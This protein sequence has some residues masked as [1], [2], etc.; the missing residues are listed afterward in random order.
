MSGR[1]LWG[2]LRARLGRLRRGDA[3]R[4]GLEVEMA[5]LSRQVEEMSTCLQDLCREV[6]R[7]GKWHLEWTVQL[8]DQAESWEQA[9]QV[10]RR[11]G[12]RY[13]EAMAELRREGE[14]YRE[15]VASVRDTERREAQA[16]VLAVL[17]EQ[18]L[19]LVDGLEAAL[20]SLSAQEERGVATGEV[21][22]HTQG[23]CPEPEAL[24]RARAGYPEPE[25]DSAARAGY[26]EREAV[27]QAMEGYLTRCQE[28]LAGLGIERLE[29]VGRQFDPYCHRAVEAIPVAEESLAGKVLAEVAAG[30]AW[31]GQVIR[32][33]Q[34]VVGKWPAGGGNRRVG[35]EPTD[36]DR[37]ARE[38]TGDQG[39][40]EVTGAELAGAEEESYGDDRGNRSGHDE[41]GS[42][43]DPG[44]P[45]PGPDHS[46]GGEVAALGGGPLSGGGP[47]GGPSGAEPVR[48]LPGADHQIREEG[49]GTGH[50]PSPG[51]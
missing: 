39:G 44:G 34:V 38:L 10:L 41:L 8:E 43:G 17:A 23:G 1:G 5:R 27:R 33:A 49:D 51:R 21:V 29:T 9:V 35:T 3:R 46:R 4:A 30:Y 28:I 13:R 11:E 22:P 18:L 20:R 2:R 12:E 19:P 15:R 32:Y 48:P 6:A 31:Q 50:Q 26:V 16:E 45:S 36:T 37:A 40:A 24:P 14:R 25:G 7:L 47:A 42:G